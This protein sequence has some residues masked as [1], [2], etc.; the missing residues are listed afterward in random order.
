MTKMSQQFKYGTLENDDEV[1]TVQPGQQPPQQPPGPMPPGVP[2]QMQIQ[3]MAPPPVSQPN[4]SFL[5]DHT[6]SSL[7][8]PRG[9]IVLPS[10]IDGLCC[11]YVY[12]NVYST[13]LLSVDNA[14]QTCTVKMYS[15]N[16]LLNLISFLSML[17]R[18]SPIMNVH[19]VHTIPC[20]VRLIVFYSTYSIYRILHIFRFSGRYDGWQN[21]AIAITHQVANYK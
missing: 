2:G 8:L 11:F 14:V 19:G 10:P 17:L 16:V 3:W 1:V 15:R 12:V 13:T 7:L 20:H 6:A 21:V 5:S 9:G 4:V 18:L